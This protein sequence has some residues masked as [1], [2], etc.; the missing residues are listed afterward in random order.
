M[1]RIH[2]VW[3]LYLFLG[4]LIGI[5]M[6]GA[7]IPITSTM[8]RWFFRRRGFMSGFVLTGT[9]VAALVTPTFADWLIAA[10]GWRNAF[11]IMGIGTLLIVVLTAQFFKRDPSQIGLMPYGAT[12][13]GEKLSDLI[14]K[15]LSLRQAFLTKQFWLTI[16]MLFS[17]GYCMFTV[18]V[19]IVPYATDLN[20]STSNAAKILGSMG[21]VAIIGRLLLGTLADRIGSQR[22][23]II[24]FIL[25]PMGL[26]LLVPAK[27]AWVLYLF[28]VT[29][30]MAQ[31][32]MGA[33]ESPLVAEIF[34]L[35]SHGLIYGVLGL[36]FTIG[37][38]I[39]PWLAG[40]IFDVMG[41]YKMAFA[42]CAAFGLMG[43][44]LTILIKPIRDD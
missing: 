6:S 20:I 9:S 10:Y 36:G 28:T 42:I 14:I 21:G 12:T 7:W 40:Y 29:F 38:A 16:F 34:G 32:G 23:F 4:I 22:I 17:F 33:A 44:V 41:S 43:L 1:S 3:Q 35:R 30:G 39:G 2:A 26:F 8:V 27:E 25:M 11:S 13:E 19:H 31:G 15:G 5:G 24:G 18:I 37:G